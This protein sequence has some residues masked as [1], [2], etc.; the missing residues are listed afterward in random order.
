MRQSI[1]ENQQA[2]QES[3]DEQEKEV[4]SKQKKR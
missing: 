4:V 2:C 3:S 1:N